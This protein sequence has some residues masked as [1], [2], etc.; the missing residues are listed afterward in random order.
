VLGDLTQLRYENIQRKLVGE[1]EVFNALSASELSVLVEALTECKYEAG[2]VI[3][4]QGH[5]GDAFFLLRSGEVKVTVSASAEGMPEEETT[6][7]SHAGD[8]SGK[9]AAVMGQTEVSTEVARLREGT[10]FGEMALLR[11]EPRMASVTAVTP[12]VCLTISRKVFRRVLGPMQQLIEREAGRRKEEAHRLASRPHFAMEDLKILGLLGVGTFAKVFLVEHVATGEVFALKAMRKRLLIEL[13]QVEHMKNE[14]SQMSTCDHPFLIRLI[15]T[16]QAEH[17]VFLV[18]E[19]ALGGELFTLLREKGR[20]DEPTSRFYAG[21]VISAFAHLHD[22]QI[23]HRDLKPENVLVDKEGYIKICDFGFAKKLVADRT[24]TLC[25]TPEFIAPEIIANVGHGLAADWWSFGVFTFELLTGTPP[26]VDD[27]PMKLYQLILRGHY[28]WPDSSSRD[29]G[30]QGG[31]VDSVEGSFR[32]ASPRSSRM[33]SPSNDSTPVG[34]SQPSS[35]AP[36]TV[37]EHAQ[38][39]I[40]RLLIIN[41]V[42]RLGSIKKG[43]REVMGHPFF[44][45]LDVS[46]LHMKTSHPPHVPSIRSITDRANF[47]VDELDD[48]YVPECADLGIPV[49]NEEQKLFDGH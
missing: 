6:Q 17:E 5:K 27:D 42:A 16:F 36:F 26:F 45:L 8:K 40:S 14:K 20:F 28:S 33:G 32:G 22:R 44:K 46:K 47:Q 39:L 23:V 4:R 29:G 34:S 18:L 30:E 35:S 15:T 13:K 12:T 37:G 21:C 11:G 9:A 31:G 41:P 38:N 2:E 1:I 10:Y 3:I 48:T 19:A 24:F 43:A 49:S 25:G 7:K